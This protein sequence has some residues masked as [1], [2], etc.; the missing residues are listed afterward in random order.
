M[1]PATAAMAVTPPTAPPTIAP[2][3]LELLLEVSGWDTAPEGW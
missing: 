1:T 2:V 3:L